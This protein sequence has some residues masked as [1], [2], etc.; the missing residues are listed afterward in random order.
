[1][2]K[3]IVN[4]DSEQKA[5]ELIQRLSQADLGEVRTRVLHRSQQTGT[6]DD[7]V[8]N[9]MIA[10]GMGSVDVRP[11]YDPNVP[12]AEYNGEGSDQE[13]SANIPTTAPEKQGLQVLIQV[14]DQHEDAVRGIIRKYAPQ[15]GSK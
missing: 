11:S 4:F 14:D 1:M 12:A 9:S 3:I 6:S 10:P 2:A 15:R 13:V 5:Q 8:Q 7:D